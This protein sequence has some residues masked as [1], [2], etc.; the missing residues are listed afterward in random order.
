VGRRSGLTDAERE[1]ASRFCRSF[2]RA[3]HQLDAGSSPEPADRGPLGIVVHRAR[4]SVRAEVELRVG[5]QIR[6]GH[7][8][9]ATRV[10]A[11]TR[12]VIVATGRPVTFR[13]ASEAAHDGEHAA[14]VLLE[15]RD[16]AV[17]L[18]SA[19]AAEPDGSATARA[20]LR[21]LDGLPG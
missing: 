12:A 18:G 14:V 15:G 21:A 10:E 20:A 1:V 2:G 13:Y 4:D 6:T 5:D 17:S 16:N 19:V 9:A 3:V 7:G 11:I 8:R